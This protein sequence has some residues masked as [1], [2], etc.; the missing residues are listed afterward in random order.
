MRLA[1]LVLATA[2]GLAACQSM[3]GTPPDPMPH[4][5]ARRA[6]PVAVLPVKYVDDCTTDFH[7]DARGLHAKPDAAA[8]L[9]TSGDMAATSAAKSSGTTQTDLLV[10]TIQHYADALRADPYNARATLG[11]A[12]AYDRVLRKGC[13]LAML[14][15]LE[16]LAQNPVIAP[17]AGHKIDDVVD[18]PQWFQGYRK[19]ALAA[20]NH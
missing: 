8:T 3:Y 12:V 5:R 16:D 4:L 17:D 6:P 10:R 1:A 7:R 20:V 15:R 14:R 19:D 13:A 11:L 2:V 9:V 18:N